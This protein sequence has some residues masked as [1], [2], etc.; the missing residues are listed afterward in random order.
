MAA[1]IN[2]CI[3]RTVVP[4]V[5]SYRL[6][7]SYVL[8]HVSTK[9]RR[10]TLIDLS[11]LLTS[12]IRAIGEALEA[13]WDLSGSVV[14]ARASQVSN[15]FTRPKATNVPYGLQSYRVYISIHI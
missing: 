2:V 15:N 13:M 4:A 11:I 5:Q 8:S 1:G 10:S 9:S 6:G 14:T 7:V 3:P 12:K